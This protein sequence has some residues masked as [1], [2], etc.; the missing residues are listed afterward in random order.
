MTGTATGTRE[1]RCL[2]LL[3]AGLL[4]AALL[5]LAGRELITAIY[6]GRAGALLNSLISGQAAHGLDRYLADFNRF[7]AAACAA[8]LLP[9]LACSLLP[10][11]IRDRLARLPRE[12]LRRLATRPDGT[13]RPV[14]T[15]L[16]ILLIATAGAVY[17]YNAWRAAAHIPEI[18]ATGQVT[19]LS[20]PVPCDDRQCYELE[21]A[22]PELA[23]TEKVMLRLGRPNAGVPGRGTALFLSGWTGNYWWQWDSEP[24][25]AAT[26]EENS[27]DRR[28]SANHGMIIDALRAAGFQTVDVKWERGWF[29]AAAGSREN[30][31][32]LACKPAT[33]VRWVY[34]TLHEATPE[35]AFCATGHSNGA[36]E[37]AYLLSRYGMADILSLVILEAGPNWAR[38]DHACLEDAAHGDLFDDLNGRSTNDLAFGYPNDGSG[39]CARE[40]RLWRE[41]FRR[42]GVAVDDEWT[43]RYPATQVAFLFGAADPTVTGRHGA[44]YHDWL[45]QA[46]TPLLTRTDV[47]GSGHIPS[48]DPAGAVLMRDLF[49]AECRPR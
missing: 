34:E 2:F 9:L 24:G 15:T 39:A 48:G 30:P 13:G 41:T 32:L 22:C 35:H 10:R 12:T 3:L 16:L 40:R 42:T 44:Y 38:L 7:Y 33:L 37:L 27:E 21:I 23:D 29:L 5:W 43:Y 31:P 19:L 8:V 20:G 26:E 4:C 6:H 45:L 11:R 49:L 17:G 47:P 14:F 46:G 1:N 28:I 25:T 36:A 18:Y